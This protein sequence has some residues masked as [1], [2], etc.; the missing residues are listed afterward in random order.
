MTLNVDSLQLAKHD[1]KAQPET[2]EK[3]DNDELSKLLSSKKKID[4]TWFSKKEDDLLK[5]NSLKIIK[6]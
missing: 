1:V 2:S 5:M 4:E 6:N 3:R